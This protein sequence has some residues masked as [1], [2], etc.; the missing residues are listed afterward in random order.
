MIKPLLEEIYT[1]KHEEYLVGEVREGRYDIRTND[2]AVILPTIWTSLVQPF[3]TIKI[4]FWKETPPLPRSS[5]KVE[6]LQGPRRVLY[7]DVVNVRDDAYSRTVRPSEHDDMVT[8]DVD[9]PIHSPPPPISRNASRDGTQ[10]T[11]SERNGTEDEEIESETDLESIESTVDEEETPEVVELREPF[12]EVN[13]PM[14]ADGNKLS[15]TVDTSRV[16]HSSRVRNALESKVD[17]SKQTTGSRGALEGHYKTLKITKALQVQAET[18]T[19]ILVHTLPGPTTSQLRESATITWHHIQAEQLD[20]SRFKQTCLGIPNMSDRLRML[21]RE[22]L[23]KIEKRKVKAFQHGWFIEPGTVLRADEKGQ[24]DPQTVIFSCIPYFDLQP[25]VKP[26]STTRAGDRLY[27]PRTLMQSYYA[28]EDVRERDSEQAY[29]KFGNTQS[30]KLVYVPNM[31]MMNIST[32]VVVTCGHK[33][34]AEEMIKSIVIVEEDVRE[35]GTTNIK[36]A[37]LT[38]I[39]LTDWDSR[40][41]LYQLDACRSYFQMEQ[42][43]RDLR[44]CAGS[45]VRPKSL[46]VAWESSEGR[47]VITPKSWNTIIKRT[48]QIFIDLVALDEKDARKFQMKPKTQDVYLSWSVATVPPFFHWPFATDKEDMEPWNG[49]QGIDVSDTSYTL[50]C[51][52]LTEKA[53][54]RET[55]DSDNTTNEVDESFTSTAF[56]KTIPEDTHDHVTV[57]FTN[58]A[59][60]THHASNHSYHANLLV[61]Q[62]ASIVEKTTKLWDIVQATM[63]LFVSDTE[64][65][66][67]IILRKVWGAMGR[68]HNFAAEVQTRGEAELDSARSTESKARKSRTDTAGWYIRDGRQRSLPLVDA[69][70]NFKHSLRHCRQCRSRSAFDT[71]EVAINHVRSHA[72]SQAGTEQAPSGVRQFSPPSVTVELN[73]D[74]WVVEARQLK[75]EE[76]NDGALKILTQSCEDVVQLLLQITEL[77]DGVRNEDGE[78]SDL[79]KFPRK[80]HE[81]FRQVVVFY[82]AIERALHYTDKRCQNSPNEKYDQSDDPPYSER[83]LEVLK[84]FAKGAQQSV[85]LARQELCNMVMPDTFPDVMKGL[86]L[87]PEYVCGWLM[88]RLLVKPLEE[89]MA[90]GDM[91]REYMSKI[92]SLQQSYL[93]EI[94]L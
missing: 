38:N 4:S 25:I 39:R 56:Y 59:S 54:L 28:Y 33:P 93:L 75:L 46:L 23:A 94:L 80:L 87:G 2:G 89:H 45:R 50:Q 70:K 77:A 15:F 85:A 44:T 64:F 26:T 63:R 18:K 90:I 19:I 21:T 20:F 53:M 5:T 31:W 27:P 47:T 65:N 71:Y 49:S 41:H 6:G 81:A 83:G 17:E 79:Y 40:V 67:G 35:L 92:V 72:K 76:T 57:Q 36:K 24:F 69:D 51:L 13:P 9:V 61:G 7:E 73:Y 68:V 88:R 14:D 30:N 16:G 86:S 52:E 78:K 34:L 84:R 82:L 42:K 22:L 43:L 29:K 91:Y 66:R 11:G 12:R 3:T 60:S 32:N 1:L 10:I 74:D 58:L 48:H 55:L 37:N 62:R 8:I